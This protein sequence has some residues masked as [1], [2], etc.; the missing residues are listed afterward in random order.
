MTTP[1]FHAKI[2]TEGLMLNPQEIEEYYEEYITSLNDYLPD[3]IVEIDLTLLQELELLAYEESREEDDTLLS[4]SFYVFESEE[5]L[6]LFNQKFI[7]WIVPVLIEHVPSTYALI[8]VNEGAELHL[9]MAFS[10]QGIYNHSGLILKILEKF[11]QEIEE[12]EKELL[13][14]KY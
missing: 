5:K 14:I 13:K 2:G 10:T 9:E 3:G 1:Q 6:T 12:N 4:Y 11:L 7:I 8:A